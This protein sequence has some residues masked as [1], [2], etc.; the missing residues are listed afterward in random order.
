[1]IQAFDAPGLDRHASGDQEPVTPRPD[2]VGARFLKLEGVHG[3]RKT[4]LDQRSP[5]NADRPFRHFLEGDDVRPS[6]SDGGH[7]A[8]RSDSPAVQVPREELHLRRVV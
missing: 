3:E 1:L 5:Q 4:A 8:S 6:T 2:E 7:L